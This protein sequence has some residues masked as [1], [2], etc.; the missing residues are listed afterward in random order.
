METNNRTMHIAR[1]EPRA[2]RRAGSRLGPYL[3]WAVVFADIG[4]SVYYAPG[5]LYKQV[6]L[7]AGLFVSM[8]LV[9]FLLLTLNMLK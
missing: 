5:I 8:T 9:V 6:G 1:T 3:C 4:T 7:L 2:T